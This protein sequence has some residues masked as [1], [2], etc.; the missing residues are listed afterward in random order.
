M[1]GLPSLIFFTTW[2]LMPA[3]FRVRA[4]PPVET[5]LKPR[6]TISRAMDVM[7]RLSRSHTLMKTLP[8]SGSM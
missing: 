6:R 4:V 1:F 2:V 3:A 8:P 7:E 5:T